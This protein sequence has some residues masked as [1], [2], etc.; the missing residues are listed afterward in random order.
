MLGSWIRKQVGEAL[1]EHSMSAK[2]L[3]MGMSAYGNPHIV[4][5]VISN[6][7]LLQSGSTLAYCKD[8]KEI[9]DQII[10]LHARERMG[11]SSDVNIG[12]FISSGSNK[13]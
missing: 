2:P 12:P 4:V 10:T 8:Q 13:L 5:H 1:Y 3:A 11:I 6:G 9:S 7:Y